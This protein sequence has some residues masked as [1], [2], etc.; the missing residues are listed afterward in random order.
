MNKKITMI[1]KKNFFF[2]LLT[3]LM[4]IIACLGFTFRES[5]KKKFYIPIGIIGIYLVAQRE[6]IRKTNRENILKKIK[7]FS[8]NK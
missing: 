2:T 7:N 6:Y 8:K 4:V 3:P 1:S 5:R